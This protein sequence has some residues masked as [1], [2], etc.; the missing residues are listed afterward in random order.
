[1][2]VRHASP[3]ASAGRSEYI[4]HLVGEGLEWHEANA[5]RDSKDQ[6]ESNKAGQEPHGSHQNEVRVDA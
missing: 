4:A 5:H 2:K 1:M 6:V 3:A